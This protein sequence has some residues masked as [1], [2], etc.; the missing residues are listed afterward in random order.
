M[1]P[2]SWRMDDSYDP[3]DDD[4]SAFHVYHFIPS[5]WQFGAHPAL[6]P[7]NGF[8]CLEMKPLASFIFTW[9]RSLDV[10]PN[11][12]SARFDQSILGC[13]LLYLQTIL[14]NHSVQTL[15]ASNARLLTFVWFKSLRS[16]LYLFQRLSSVS[17]WKEG[18]GFLRGNPHVQICPYNREGQHF[19]DLVQD[20][21]ASLL[22]QWSRDRLRSVDAFYSVSLVPPSHFVQLAALRLPPSVAQPAADPPKSKR[23]ARNPKRSASTSSPDFIAQQP[24][25]DLVTTPLNPRACFSTF[26][27]A[28]PNG[29]RMPQLS[30]PDGKFSLICFQSAAGPPFNKCNLG[31]CLRQQQEKSK[32]PRYRNSAG[33]PPPFCHVDLSQPYWAGQPESF[34]AP[35]VTFLRLPGVAATIRPSEF[36]KSKTPSTPW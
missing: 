31:D 28:P 1:Q 17:M 15:W 20:Y 27:T 29:T 2:G 32:N 23:E 25:F 7:S 4:P 35:V 5:L 19:L 6:L 26:A 9:F 34:W 14:D 13:R 30:N 16:L 8:S 22:L 36:L 33:G 10:S 24:L 11:F 18:G 12:D 21:D 3:A